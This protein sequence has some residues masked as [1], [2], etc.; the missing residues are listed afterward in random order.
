M[1]SFTHILHIVLSTVHLHVSLFIIIDFIDFYDFKSS[2]LKK[3]L[4]DSNETSAHYRGGVCQASI[5]IFN[6][7]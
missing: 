4:A 5:P 3:Y 7:F 1:C 2:V 6:Q